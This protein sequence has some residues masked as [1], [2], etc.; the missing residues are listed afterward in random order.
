MYALEGTVIFEKMAD[1]PDDTL[2]PTLM[3]THD[4][5]LDQ[6]AECVDVNAHLIGEE[7]KAAPSRRLSQITDY[8]LIT[9]TLQ[10]IKAVKRQL[11]I[12]LRANPEQRDG[13][14]TA[15]QKIRIAGSNDHLF[16]LEYAWNDGA[17]ASYPWKYQLILTKDGRLIN[18]FMAERYATGNVRPSGNCRHT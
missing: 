13:H 1:N 6:L 8:P 18:Y 14:F 11:N 17:M 3:A 15:F 10:L 5:D 2:L 16:L 7:E 4:I 9:D 12:G